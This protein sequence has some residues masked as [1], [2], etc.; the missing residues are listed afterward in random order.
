MHAAATSQVAPS[1]LTD[2]LEAAAVPAQPLLP[3][4]L[5]HLRPRG[6]K[7][8]GR[9]VP[10]LWQVLVPRKDRC[11]G[12]RACLQHRP[13][14]AAPPAAQRKQGQHAAQP[15]G[16]SHAPAAPAE[17]RKRAAEVS[18]WG[19]GA[20]RQPPHAAAARRGALLGVLPPL[21]ALLPFLWAAAAVAAPAQPAA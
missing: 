1:A 8:A 3:L 14:H 2:S 7:M 20:G 13:P 5:R 18:G 4:P 10:P 12:G 9:L 11:L 15:A 6:R 19:A 17:H 16:Q 21:A